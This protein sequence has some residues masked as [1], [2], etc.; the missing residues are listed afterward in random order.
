MAILKKHF[1]ALSC[2]CYKWLK[3]HIHLLILLAGLLFG[4]CMT[5]HLGGGQSTE[6]YDGDDDGTAILVPNKNSS[7][8]SSIVL[9]V[10]VD[11]LWHVLVVL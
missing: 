6:P 5:T 11:I 10:L 3:F 7:E 8:G 9:Q 2:N 4:G 1:V